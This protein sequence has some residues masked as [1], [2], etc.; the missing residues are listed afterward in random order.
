MV[1]FSYCHQFEPTLECSNMLKLTGFDIAFV[2]TLLIWVVPEVWLL[3]RDRKLAPM[4]AKTNGKIMYY[5]SIIAIL[6]C[7]L[8][9]KYNSL[10]IPITQ[11]RRMLIGIFII[12]GGLLIRWW[13]M[14]SL[15][16]YFTVVVTVKVGQ[17]LIKNGPYKYIR[18]PSYTGSLLAGIGLGFGL[19]NW[20]GL[21]VMLILPCISYFLRAVVEEQVMVASFGNG[22]LIY[23][24]QT[25]RFVPFI[26]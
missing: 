23:M 13:A 16:K 24:S 6:A 8:L 12:W 5:F 22:Y 9:A 1:L 25:S 20:I 4:G 18:H 17:K 2:I 21:A 14:Y 26:H 7:L 15:G 11:D 3:F 10:T 19:G